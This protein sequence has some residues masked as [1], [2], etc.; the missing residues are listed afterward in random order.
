MENN[1]NVQSVIIGSEKAETEKLTM[2]LL[3]FLTGDSK[4]ITLVIKDELPIKLEKNRSYLKIERDNEHLKVNSVK[5]DN[6]GIITEIKG[7]NL[8]G[9]LSTMILAEGDKTV[10]FWK[11]NEPRP[12]LILKVSAD[13][14]SADTNL[15]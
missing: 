6:Y 11:K 5:V 9:R 3:S 15:L 10:S 1:P 4:R 14:I 7:R 12:A 13:K 8:T 2:A